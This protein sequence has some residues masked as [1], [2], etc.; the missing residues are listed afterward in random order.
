M[1]GDGVNDAP[2]LR[3]ADVGLAV[4]TGS[5]AARSQAGVELLG[6]DLRALPLLLDGARRLRRA[7]RTNLGWT[8]AYNAVLLALAAAGKLHPLLAAGAMI[9]SSL[10]VSARSWRLLHALP[11]SPAAAREPA[12]S[13]PPRADTLCA[14]RAAEA[15]A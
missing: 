1:T 5:A 8:L 12:P 7:V 9:L 10:M 13:L 6:E 14:P 4:A 11:E 15:L 2:A 3:E